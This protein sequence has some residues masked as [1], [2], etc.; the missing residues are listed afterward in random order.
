MERPVAQRLGR[1]G[2]APR[3][4]LGPLVGDDRVE[5]GHQAAPAS[6]WRRVNATTPSSTRAAAPESIDAA[7]SPTPSCR[8]RA[9]PAPPTAAAALRQPTSR[10]GPGAPPSTVPSSAAASAVDPTRSAASGAGASPAPA[11]VT[12]PS[13]TRP[14]ATSATTVSP[15]SA[16]SSRPPVPCT[17]QARSA[18]RRTSASATGST[19]RRSKTPNT[20]GR[21]PAGLVSG[22]STLKSVRTPSSRR[23]PT[24]CRIAGWSAGAWRKTKPVVPRHAPRTA[25]GSSSRTPSASRT[26]DPPAA[27]ESA[28]LPCWATGTPA[29][30]TTSPAAVETLNVEAPSPPVPHVSTASGGTPGIGTACARIT[31]AAPTSSPTVSPFMRSATRSAPIWAGLALPARMHSI[32]AAISDS[33]RARPSTTR[34]RASWSL[35]PPLPERRD[36]R[37]S[38]RAAAENGEWAGEALDEGHRDARVAGGARPGRDDDAIGT[39]RRH[40][41][42]GDRIVAAD[43][44]VGAEFAEVLDEVVG[45]GVVVVY[46]QE[47]PR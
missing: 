35:T 32:T 1:D 24:A 34:A 11:A 30:A 18:S 16:I 25:A 28:R 38:S 13:R 17:T 4:D 5:H 29:P 21:T 36:G 27:P 14:S 45:E 37:G 8:S 9:M 43:V 33:E 42:E 3:T 20:R 31:R 44:K 19:Q 12:V 2:P 41:V 15:S 7:A 47:P 46:H 6:A 23:G 26:S 10:A 39:E 22:P 40:L